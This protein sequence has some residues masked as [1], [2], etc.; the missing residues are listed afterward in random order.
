MYYANSTETNLT[1][2]C[3]VSLVMYLSIML[4][5]TTVI[6]VA[7][8]LFKSVDAHGRWKCPLPRDDLD[9]N[10]VHIEFDNTGN[11]NGACGPTSGKWGY[12]TVT[13]LRPGWVTLTWEESISHTGKY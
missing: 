10:G 3:R 1:Q 13:T 2:N 9:D 8:A 5:I 11:K 12:G 4:Q 7:L 6:V